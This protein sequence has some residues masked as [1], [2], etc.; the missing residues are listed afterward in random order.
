MLIM[1]I[2]LCN[3]SARNTQS[4]ERRRIVPNITLMQLKRDLEASNLD[5]RTVYFFAELYEHQIALEQA[6]EQMSG[7][8]VGLAE[9]VQQFVNLHE[10]TQTKLKQMMQHGQ[11]D[12]VDVRSE[13]IDKG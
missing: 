11:M 1:R 6:F 2:Q 3:M 4:S 5:K 10:A 9:S 12:G 7:I 13:P 8:V